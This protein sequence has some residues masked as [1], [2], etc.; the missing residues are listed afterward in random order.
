MKKT[1]L[2]MVLVACAGL[3]MAFPIHGPQEITDIWTFRVAPIFGSGVSFPNIA[4]T[5]DPTLASDATG[6]NA[7]ARSEF[8][9][10]LKV[11]LVPFGTMTNGTTETTSYID[12]T[13][14]GEW[15][16]V[17]ADVVE[18]ASATIYRIGTTSYKAAF[19][20]TAATGDGASNTITSDNLEADESIG[21]WIY[22]DTNLTAAWLTLVLTDNGGA[23]TFNFPAVSPNV[24]TWVEIDITS[25]AAGTGDQIT[26]VAVLL[27]A[28]GAT[29]LGAFNIYLDGM[30]KWDAADELALGQNLITGGVLRVLTWVKADAGTQAHDMAALAENTDW[31]PNYQASTDVI[32]QI[33]DQSTKA[34]M[35][36]VAY[37]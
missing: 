6:G 29:G 7:G 25:L 27:S 30:W 9:G 1:V 14:T 16:P 4:L 12:D 2:A 13:P 31:F 19:A 5:G 33:T 18:S 35:A 24:W 20:A 36:L 21:F 3:L 15:A 34:G 26:A 8:Q 17:D 11:D 10:L 22:S 23:R 32:V 37:Q 28:A